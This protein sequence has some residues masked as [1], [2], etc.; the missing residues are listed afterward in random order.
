MAES[1][2]V[3]TDP[4]F[5]VPLLINGKEITTKITFPVTSPTSLKQIWHS[6]SASLEDAGAAIK[7]AQAAFKEW[8]KTKPAA[9]RAIFMKAADII[10][11]RAAELGDYMK[12]ETG[13][14]SPFAD[15]LNIPK[16]AD[17]LRDVAGRLTSIQ[18]TIPSCEQ[19]GTSALIVKEPYGVVLAIAPW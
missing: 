2:V 10:D 7:A 1:K 17:V 5:T 13:A 15:G 12:L 6:S 9:K 11:A 16:C 8:S 18:G 4:S 19:E 3:T 14:T